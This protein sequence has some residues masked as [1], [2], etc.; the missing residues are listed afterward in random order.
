M[1]KLTLDSLQIESFETSAALPRHAG[2]VQAHITG[3]R[4]PSYAPCASVDLVCQPD[5]FEPACGPTEYL[6]CTFGCSQANTCNVCWIEN[7][8]NCTA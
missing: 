6:D 5:T 1:R 4:C 8:S 7:T 3:S 2:T